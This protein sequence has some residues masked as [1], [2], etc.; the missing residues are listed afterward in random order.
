MHFTVTKDEFLAAAVL[1]DAHIE[2]RGTIPILKS[3]Q[4][5]VG[6]ASLTLSAT[7]VD[8]WIDSTINAQVSTHG[9]SAVPGREL[10][11]A[12]RGFTHSSV[13]VFFAD[14]DHGNHLVLRCG[15]DVK[16][17]STYPTEDLVCRTLFHGDVVSKTMTPSGRTFPQV[18]V[19]LR[20]R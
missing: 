13:E 9:Q 1:C 7:D 5:E 12:L 17:L 20:A 19:C 4:L 15:E 14:T 11:K 8:V 3:I 6:T 18:D 10:V 2:H 16:H